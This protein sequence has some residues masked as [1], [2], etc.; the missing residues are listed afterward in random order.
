M[1]DGSWRQVGADAA[2]QAP[3]ASASAF[4]LAFEAMS[5]HVVCQLTAAALDQCLKLRRTGVHT[6]DCQ[7]HR[8]Q[9][10]ECVRT[11]VR[12]TQA[13]TP[14]TSILSSRGA[15]ERVRVFTGR[16]SAE[17]NHALL[18]EALPGADVGKQAILPLN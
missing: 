14:T 10:E 5:R 16:S 3:P 1:S 13:L 2:P 15:F 6:N 12:T 8:E 11:N 18:G 17:K 7:G 9:Y 4:A